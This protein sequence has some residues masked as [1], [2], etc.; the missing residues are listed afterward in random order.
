MDHLNHYDDCPELRRVDELI[1]NY[2]QKGDYEACFQGCLELA[3]QGYALA[4]CQVGYFSHGTGD[5]CQFGQSALLDEAGGGAWRP[6]RAEK[7]GGNGT[8]PGRQTTMTGNTTFKDK[9]IHW[10]QIQ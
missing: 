3:E 10:E 5:A 4:E 1:E 2:Y 6:G 7:S 9:K 8:D